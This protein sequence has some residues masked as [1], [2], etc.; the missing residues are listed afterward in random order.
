MKR[1]TDMTVGSPFRHLISF[2]LPLILTNIGQQLYMI[3]DGAIVGRGVGVQALAA[4]GATDWCYWLILWTVVGSTQGLSTF[5]SR[6][7]GDGD[8]K[9]MNKAIAMGTLLSAAL[10]TVLSAIGI[11]A[12]EPL[13]SLLNTPP[14]IASDAKLYLTTL[15]SGALVV[16]AYNMASSVLRG[17]GDGKTPL[18]AMVIAAVLN[19]GLDL[20]FVLVFEMGVFGAALASVIAQ[21]AAFLYCLFVIL[22]TDCIRLDR[23]AWRLDPVM[24]KKMTL[25][26]IPVMLQYMLI[27]LGGI[28]LQSAIN[29]EGSE[30]IAGYTA[31]NKVYGLLESS[32]ISLGLAT[33]TFVSQNYGAGLYSRVKKG[34]LAASVIVVAMAGAVTSLTLIFREPLMRVFIDAAKEGGEK[35]LGISVHY[36]SIIS[37]CL[38][39]LYLLHIFRN[40]LLS[41]GRSLWPM[42]SGIA[43]F[44][45][46]VVMSKAVI[47]LMGSDALFVSEPVAWLGALLCVM[48]PYLF[49]QRKMPKTDAPRACR[50]Q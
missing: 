36:L 40:A 47:H 38:F 11:I 3:A 33:C 8:L 29:L 49:S 16:T 37:V 1:I 2:A 24:L 43:E 22:R 14:D 12:A 5:V 39:I 32:A 48:L 20:I 27:S 10:G 13:L 28:V 23:E 46:R 6:S 7:F 34:V 31:T 44:F 4:V 26:G 25:F 42:M 17:L 19:V 50:T 9:Q 41:M 45:A 15:L 21:L 35:A 18:I 30:F